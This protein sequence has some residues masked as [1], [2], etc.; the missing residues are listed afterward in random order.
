MKNNKGLTITE[1]VISITL[2][3]I[4]L[5]F[6]LNVLITVRN[7][8]NSSQSLSRLLINQALIIKDIETDFID[9]E[10]QQVNGCSDSV[11][12]ENAHRIVPANADPISLH[13]LEFTFNEALVSENKG[14]LLY[15]SYKYSNTDSENLSV[16]GYKRGSHKIM[17]ETDVAPSKEPEFYGTVNN[18]CSNNKCVLKI[19]LPLLGSDGENYGINLSY[20][21]NKTVITLPGAAYNF[22]IN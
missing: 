6:L 7:E 4:V 13:C 3:S 15:Y 2:V 17:R 22:Q 20:V 16:V 8:N 12:T 9:Y 11:I 14:Y 21:S 18:L 10:L 5:V 19:N 1:I